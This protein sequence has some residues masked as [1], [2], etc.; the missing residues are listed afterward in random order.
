MQ[1]PVNQIYILKLL[2]WVLFKPSISYFPLKY[3]CPMTSLANWLCREI[4]TSASWLATLTNFTTS[5]R[6]G[7][8]I[9]DSRPL[10]WRNIFTKLVRERTTDVDR[11]HR[12]QIERVSALSLHWRIDRM[13]N[14]TNLLSDLTLL[15]F[16]EQSITITV[17]VWNRFSGRIT[18]TQRL[19]FAKLLGDSKIS[20]LIYHLSHAGG[21]W[22][23]FGPY[24]RPIGYARV[25][26]A[27]SANHLDVASQFDSLCG[28]ISFITFSESFLHQQSLLR[29]YSNAC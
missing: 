21:F 20:W 6:H 11:H 27:L 17:Q 22:V 4:V 7:I 5:V 26:R 2:T 3:V 8:P 23:S 1:Q 28:V 12:S 18:I 9:L 14:H 16:R 10:Q 25:A 13:Y 15:L 29:P 19:L 24:Y